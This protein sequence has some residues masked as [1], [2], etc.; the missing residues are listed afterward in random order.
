VGILMVKIRIWKDG[1]EKLQGALKDMEANSK[2]GQLWDLNYP[3]YSSTGK[4]VS[5]SGLSRPRD[6]PRRDHRY[7]KTL[8]RKRKTINSYNKKKGV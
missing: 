7:Y 4:I 6:G 3:G 5:G 2:V 1:S 8:D